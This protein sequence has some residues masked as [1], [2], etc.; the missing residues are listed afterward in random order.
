MK[1]PTPTKTNTS[2]EPMRVALSEAISAELSQALAAISEQVDDLNTPNLQGL[3]LA[4]QAERDR[5]RSA[6]A[7]LERQMHAAHAE[8]IFELTQLLL[9]VSDDVPVTQPSYFESVKLIRKLPHE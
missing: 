4:L 3:A 9:C 5:R 7:E 2:A 6:L 8:A 1:K